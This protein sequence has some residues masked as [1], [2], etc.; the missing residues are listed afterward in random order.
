[1]AIEKDKLDQLLDKLDQLEKQQHSLQQEIINVKNQ[2]IRLHAPPVAP[3]PVEVKKEEP[4]DD[5]PIARSVSPPP[6][7]S[8]FSSVNFEKFIG[9]NL[10]NK[11]GIA[12]LVIGVGIGAK[13]AIE[14]DMLNPLTRIVMGYL[15]GAILLFF[16]IRLKDKYKNYSAVLLSGSMAIFY[17]I[18]FLASSFYGLIPVTASFVMMVLFT[19]FTVLAALH[20]DQ[21][22]IALIGLVGAYGIPFLLS[23]NSGRYAFFFSYISIIN[24][25][26]LVIAIKKYWKLLYFSSFGLTWLIYLLWFFMDYRDEHHFSI[27]AIFLGIFFFT[28]YCTA[29]SYKILQKEIFTKSDIILITL[30]SLLFYGFGYAII[31]DHEPLNGYLGLFTLINAI[32]HFSVAFFIYK[33]KSVDRNLFYF[34]AGLVLI[35]ITV[36]VPVQL[37][38]RPVTIFWVAEAALLFWIG[39]TKK[40]SAYEKLSYPLILLAFFSQIHDW[41]D[42]S[43]FNSYQE[44][45]FVP[46]FNVDFLGSILF[47]IGAGLIYFLHKKSA[48]EPGKIKRWMSTPF[49]Y[50]VG[51]IFLLALFNSFRIEIQ[52]Y[53]E[54]LYE[55]S[56]ITISEELYDFQYNRHL[57]KFK[58]IWLINYLMIFTTLLIVANLVKIRE[59]LL[60]TVSLILAIISIL[61]FLA[62]G[63]YD[64]SELREAYIGQELANSYPITFMYLAIRYISLI[65]LAILLI[66]SVK[67]IKSFFQEKISPAAME[68]G[69]HIVILWVVSSEL[70]HWMDLYG[71]SNNY[72][73]GLSILWGLYALVMVILGI[74]KNN[75][76]LRIAAMVLYG[77]TLIKLFFYDISH[78][79]LL[80]K[81]IVFVSL[82]AIMLLVSFLYNKYKHSIFDDGENN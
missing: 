36:T 42:Y 51:G 21:K 64:I 78:L 38:G 54:Q 56:E 8:R 35:F 77:G 44:N 70:L 9:E 4:V 27:A 29:L 13:Y 25:G 1:M 71:V 59:K 22:I 40:I 79:N 52:L 23:D 68:L 72:K 76:A 75:K 6:K 49:P 53:W 69:V 11:I 10:I 15:V 61:V 18:T 80:A 33:R 82:G 60:A 31:E 7:S 28:F 39:R 66:A 73:L 43:Y 58:N 50:I 26:I 57:L 24:V 46:I 63:L 45:T 14:R 30:N 34:I 62:N 19:L 16:A 48:L 81:A 65:F 41:N 2:V 47:T 74:W 55:N 12:I 67:N 3:K 20:Y 5:R 32:V 17:F 37:D